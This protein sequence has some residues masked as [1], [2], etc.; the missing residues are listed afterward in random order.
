MCQE[1]VQSSNPLILTMFEPAEFTQKCQQRSGV[2]S[3]SYDHFQKSARWVSAPTEKW[4]CLRLWNCRNNLWTIFLLCLQSRFFA[5]FAI[6]AERNSVKRK[7]CF[8]AVSQMCNFPRVAAPTEQWR[9]STGPPISPRL[10]RET[11]MNFGT[12]IWQCWAEAMKL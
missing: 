2:Q 9:C 7:G 6:S 3:Q 8:E 10:P 4:R 12:V 11:R 1:F 5:V